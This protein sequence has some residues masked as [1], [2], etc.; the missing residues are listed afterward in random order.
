L[1]KQKRLRTIPKNRY[2]VRVELDGICRGTLPTRVLLPLWPEDFEGEIERD[3][4]QELLALLEK[5]AFS[6]LLDYLAKAEHSEFQCRNLLKRKEFDPRI[7][8]AAIQRCREQNFLS[9]ARFADVLIRSYIARKASKRA[10]I[11]KLREQR[12]PGEIWTELLEELY[13]REQAS[14]NIS[15]LLAKYCST[16]RGLPRQKLRGKAFGYLFRKGFELEE[17]QS[18]WEE[19]A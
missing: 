11:A 13:P 7:I 12:I 9:D 3:K 2:T 17:I 4:A 16:H 14:E 10:I 5:Q 8:D 15:E 18:A 6:T 19:L 1:T